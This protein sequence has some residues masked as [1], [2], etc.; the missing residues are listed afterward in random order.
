[1]GA[2]LA[3]AANA[4]QTTQ[5]AGCHLAAFSFKFTLRFEDAGAFLLGFDPHPSLTQLRNTGKSRLQTL[6]SVTGNGMIM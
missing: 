3:L 6:G 4:V 1:M 2:E 5:M